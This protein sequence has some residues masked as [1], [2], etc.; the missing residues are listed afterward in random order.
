MMIYT[1][2]ILAFMLAAAP[3]ACATFLRSKKYSLPRQLRRIYEG[4]KY[5]NSFRKFFTLIILIELIVFQYIDLNAS[6]DIARMIQDNNTSHIT[7]MQAMGYNA[8]LMTRPYAIL[9]TAMF[10]LIFFSF[11]M[12]DKMLTTLH[13]NR[14]VFV[15]TGMVA[16]LLILYSFRYLIIAEILLMILMAAY[17]YPNKIKHE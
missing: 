9:M 4:M 15:L 5:C 2:L 6:T 1:K 7:A 3:F 13:N 14:R 8:A 10:S 16:L 17:I 12:S 11:R